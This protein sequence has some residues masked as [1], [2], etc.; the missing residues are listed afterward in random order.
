MRERVFNPWTEGSLVGCEVVGI[1]EGSN[2][3]REGLGEGYCIVPDFDPFD[4]CAAEAPTAD[5]VD[6]EL[7]PLDLLAL[8]LDLLP[9]PKVGYDVFGEIDGTGLVPVG[10]AEDSCVGTSVF[11]LLEV[12]LA[13]F[14]TVCE[15]EVASGVDCP[16]FVVLVE[17]SDL[18]SDL[19]IEGP[20]VVG[21]GVPIS[22]VGEAVAGLG[23]V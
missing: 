2:V 11:A 16:V 23:V 5:F 13:D 3:E 1:N 18:D 17:L 21:P 8:A 6:L 15:Y 20:E 14:A 19:A 22:K 12:L 4:G 7:S 10:T 9:F